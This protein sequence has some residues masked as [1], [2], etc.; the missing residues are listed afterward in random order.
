[1]RF[2]RQNTTI[3][4]ASKPCHMISVS[5]LQTP[6][7][8]A[9]ISVGQEPVLMGRW[10]RHLK[11]PVAN[12]TAAPDP[13]ISMSTM[14]SGISCQSPQAITGNLE[15]INSEKKKKTKNTEPFPYTSQWSGKEA[16]KLLY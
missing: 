13:W 14:N 9:V 16:L 1:M 15:I 10:S 12:G 3:S 7:S 8:I 6:G 4:A 5:F 2:D 11:K